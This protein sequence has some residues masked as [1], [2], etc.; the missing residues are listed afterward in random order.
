MHD[1]RVGRRVEL[2]VD[3]SDEDSARNVVERLAGELF[4]NPLIE[5][6]WIGAAGS[7]AAGE[8]GE[9]GS[10]TPPGLFGTS[11]T[12]ESASRAVGDRPAAVDGPAGAE[13]SA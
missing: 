7:G 6:W 3:A 11:G 2:S 1:V 4:A 12:P 8:A 9:V 10:G 13:S 5:S